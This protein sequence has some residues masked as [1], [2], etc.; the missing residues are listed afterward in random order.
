MGPVG[1][2]PDAPV[3]VVTGL[4]SEARALAGVAGLRTRCLG[5]GPDT[6]EAA[7]RALL[8]EGA[9]ALVSAG[10]CGALDPALRPGDV[11]LPVRVADRHQEARAWP[12]DA[13]W[14]GAAMAR[15]AA[16]VRPSTG[17][18]LGSDRAVASVEG[19]RH[20]AARTGAVAVDMESHA[21][22]RVAAAAGVP[23]LVLRTVA[24]TAGD[25]LP[26]WLAGMLNRDGTPNAG[27]ALR[28]LLAGPWRLAGLLRLAARSRAAERALTAAAPALVAA[29]SARAQG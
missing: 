25:A 19:K 21:V 26:P 16:D 7:A 23:F 6:A 27:V 22:A 8:A 12:V 15:L 9:G 24:D 20:L 11:I 14:H 2:G 4:T 17:V 3:G 28:R 18:L 10:I 5:P 1:A 13:P 29:P